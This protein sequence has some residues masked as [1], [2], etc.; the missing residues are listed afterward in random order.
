MLDNGF[1]YAI[2]NLSKQK[3]VTTMTVKRTIDFSKETVADRLEANADAKLEK[4][5]EAE[6]KK[7]TKT[8]S[9]G[10]TDWLMNE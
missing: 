3:E 7:T 9:D 2:M 1:Q 6:A 10:F 4:S 5:R 8:Y